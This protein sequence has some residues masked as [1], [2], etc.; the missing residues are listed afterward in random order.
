MVAGAGLWPCRLSACARRATAFKC[1]S[2]PQEDPFHPTTLGFEERCCGPH[3]L[4]PPR[5]YGCGEQVRDAVLDSRYEVL[6]LVHT[7]WLSQIKLSLFSL[8]WRG[9]QTHAGHGPWSVTV[10]YTLSRR[11]I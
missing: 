7:L 10:Y 9:T 6:F 3:A 5:C 11:D 4:G 1:F 8:S 2:T